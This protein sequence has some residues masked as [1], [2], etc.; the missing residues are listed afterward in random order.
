MLGDVLSVFS[1]LRL[2]SLESID[3]MIYKALLLIIVKD[4]DLRDV[5]YVMLYLLVRD[6]HVT[7]HRKTM[8]VMSRSLASTVL[9]CGISSSCVVVFVVMQVLSSLVLLLILVAHDVPDTWV[10][11]VSIRLRI[12]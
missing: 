5:W 3:C 6:H 10:L 4:F 8:I 7:S 2:W 11:N 9:I 1:L 12:L